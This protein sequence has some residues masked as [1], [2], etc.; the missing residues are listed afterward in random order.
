MGF[1]EK[2]LL[3][4]FNARERP[5]MKLRQKQILKFPP[6]LFKEKLNLLSAFLIYSRIFFQKLILNNNTFPALWK[7]NRQ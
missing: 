1:Q 6:H 7:S 5:D 3:F 4:F 2:T